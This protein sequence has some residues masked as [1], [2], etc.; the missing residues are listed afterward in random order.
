MRASVSIDGVK[1][2]KRTPPMQIFE[3]L[4]KNLQK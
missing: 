3:K 2:F 4:V 1:G